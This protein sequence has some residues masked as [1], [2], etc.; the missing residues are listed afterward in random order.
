MRLVQCIALDVYI[1]LLGLMFEMKDVWVV[2]QD[3]KAVRNKHLVK[4]NVH[5]DTPGKSTR[6]HSVSR[7][8]LTN[9]I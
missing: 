4:D 6:S 2:G 1:R 7:M 9:H 3:G 5:A 8:H